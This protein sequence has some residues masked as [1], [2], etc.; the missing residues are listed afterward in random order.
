MRQNLKT[1]TR[2]QTKTK[3]ENRPCI[4]AQAEVITKKNCN[5]Y[6]D[7]TS[8]KY[9][10]AMM[11]KALAGKHIS[12]QDALRKKDSK[13]RTCR[14]VLTGRAEHRSC[15]MNYNCFKCDFDQMFE[16]TL[17]PGTGHT[18]LEMRDIKGFKIPSGFYFHSGHTWA[19]LDSGGFIRVGMDDFAFK[20]L[21][22]PSGFDLP[23]IGQELNCD[24]IGWGIKRDQNIG[25]VRSPING[26]ITKVNHNVNRSPDLPGEKPYEDGWLFTVHSRDMK[27]EIKALMDDE[28]GEKWLDSEVGVLENMIEDVAGPLSADGG[29]LTSDV[30]GNLPILGWNNLTRTFLGT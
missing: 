12:W 13:D 27:G 8:C 3:N 25:D 21:G 1:K 29:H 30:Y 17:V 5:N 26:V 7:C 2:W 23:L 11:T 16:D 28:S 9:D 4:W 15:P 18:T 10:A 14:H 22:G 20:V 6:Y 24:K 19:S